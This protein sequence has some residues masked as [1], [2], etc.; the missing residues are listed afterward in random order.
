MSTSFCQS[1]CLSITNA[2]TRISKRGIFSTLPLIQARSPSSTNRYGTTYPYFYCLGR[3]KD[4]SNCEQPYVSVTELEQAVAGYFRRV[5]GPEARLW[6]LRD[7]ILAAFAGKHAD[8]EVEITRQKAR[9]QRLAQRAMKNKEAY[10]A[11]ALSLADFKAEQDR[12][13]GEIASAGQTIAKLTVTLG[14]I[15]RSLDQALSLLLDPYKLFTE[16]PD[17][18]RL[19]LVQAVFEKLWVMDH[20]VVGSELTET[21]QELLTMD[22]KLTLTAQ[23]RTAETATDALTRISAQLVW[24]KGLGEFVVEGA[25]AP[26]GDGGV[27]E[28]GLAEDWRVGPSVEADGDGVGGGGDLAGGFEEAALQGV[29]GDG[30]VA[31]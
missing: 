10:F 28:V 13:N 3:Q 30:G 17:A 14:S 12:I 29:G 1:C 20:D 7:E 31:G 16:A 23:E 24:G 5:R 4:T 19:M 26:P 22:A 2:C 11:D 25:V 21:Y 8:G 18:V 27:G 9:I 6:T 15:E